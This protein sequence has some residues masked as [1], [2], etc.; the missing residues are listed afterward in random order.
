MTVVKNAFTFSELEEVDAASVC[1]KVN[2][3]E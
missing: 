3:A 2:Y 1:D